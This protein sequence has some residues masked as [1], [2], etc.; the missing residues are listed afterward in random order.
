MVGFMGLNHFGLLDMSLIYINPTFLWSAIIGGLIMG[1]GFVVGGFCP[2]TSVCAIAIG[3]IDAMIFIVGAFLGV[4]VFAEGYPIFE[5]LFKAT[6]LGYPRFF[7]TLGISQN[8][9]VFIFIVVSLSSL[10]KL[11]NRLSALPLIIL[12]SLQLEF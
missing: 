9:F 12:L 3:K 7:E 6:N 2:G 10:L 4:I 5:P 11:L 1:L 8:V